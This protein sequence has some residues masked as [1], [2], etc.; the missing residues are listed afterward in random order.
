MQLIT[1]WD[2]TLCAGLTTSLS[3][4]SKTYTLLPSVHNS[5][6]DADNADDTDDYNRVTGIAQLKGFSYAKNWLGETV[7]LFDVTT[8]PSIIISG[9][10]VSVSWE[11]T[12]SQ[13][14]VWY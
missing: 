12:I 8:H 3:T 7:S 13:L 2:S 4:D 11:N 1:A 10:H 14:S 9:D 6:D 5:A